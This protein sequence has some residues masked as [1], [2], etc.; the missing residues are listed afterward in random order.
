MAWN[1]YRQRGGFWPSVSLAVAFVLPA[2]AAGVATLTA[3]NVT[4]AVAWSILLVSVLLRGWVL[5]QYVREHELKLFERFVLWMTVIVVAFGYYQFIGDIL[6]LSESWTFLSPK[7]N[8]TAAFPFARVQSFALEPLYNA[9]YLFLPI[10]IL[11]V[12]FWRAKKASISEQLL[13]I[14]TLGVLLLTLSRG[15]LLGLLVCGIVLFAGTRSWRALGYLARNVGIAFAITLALLSLSGVTAAD[16]IANAQSKFTAV[17]AYTSHAIDLNEGSARTRYDLWP[18]TIRAFL[19]DPTTGVGP[20]NLPLKLTDGTPTTTLAE[21]GMMPAV[22]N[23]YLAWLSELGLL[24]VALALPLIWLILRAMW[25]STIR[26]RLDHPSAP[27]ALAL[28]SM[29]LQANSF[30]SLLLLGTWVVIGLLIA[31]MRLIGE[32]PGEATESH[33]PAQRS[34]NAAGPVSSAAA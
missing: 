17:D 34:A 14:A 21:A 13:L 16:R 9:H 19:G 12:R 10:S 1:R 11:L 5:A 29:A 27:Y 33:G 8:S 7:Y 3:F 25:I 22:N 24:G 26:A 4:V 20:G 6:G 23:D 31:G 2:V 18:D 30:H 28:S 32:R 15:A